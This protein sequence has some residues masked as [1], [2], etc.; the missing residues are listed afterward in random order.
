MLKKTVL[1]VFL[2]IAYWILSTLYYAGTFKTIE[3][4]SE[5]TDISVYTNVAGTEDLEIDREK[6]VLFISSTDRWKFV[7]GEA[8]V[9]DGAFTGARAGRVLQ[10]GR[11]EIS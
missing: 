6:G 5:L 9:R 10:K 2:G 8:A 11:R 1:L 4:H 3:P 7:N